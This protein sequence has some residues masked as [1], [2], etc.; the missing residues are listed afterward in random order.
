MLI[1]F[2]EVYRIL[3]AC[4]RPPA[5]S[6][7]SDRE[8]NGLRAAKAS[9]QSGMSP[10]LE[11]KPDCSPWPAWTAFPPWPFGRGSASGCLC[12]RNNPASRPHGCL[13]GWR[14]SWA[15]PA[16]REGARAPAR[17]RRLRRRRLLRV[18]APPDRPLDRGEVEA[19]SMT[20]G[21]RH[22]EHRPDD[23]A[24]GRADVGGQIERCEQS[25]PVGR[26][27]L[28]VFGRSIT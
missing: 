2:W 15:W 26:L 25:L 11:N 14:W 9:G 19:R 28:T 17:R 7:I 1:I 21:E 3:L 24:C 12:F 23:L 6:C 20:V 5:R 8:R 22:V 4:N 27:D 18:G 10:A 16:R 13:S